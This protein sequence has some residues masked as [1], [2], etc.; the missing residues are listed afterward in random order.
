MCVGT[1]C[2]G[3]GPASWSS[4]DVALNSRDVVHVGRALN[5]E[6]DSSCRSQSNIER[7]GVGGRV[8]GMEKAMSLKD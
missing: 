5:A 2:L 6:A 1:S 4:S 7:L 3:A 8:G